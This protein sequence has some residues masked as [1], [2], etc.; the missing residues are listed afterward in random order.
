VHS[1]IDLVILCRLAAVESENQ[2]KQRQLVD[3]ESHI[4]QLQHENELMQAKANFFSSNNSS[5]AM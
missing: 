1:W 4:N 2:Q 3:A 5:K